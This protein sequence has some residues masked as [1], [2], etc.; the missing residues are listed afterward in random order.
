MVD[1]DEHRIG[2]VFAD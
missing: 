1:K 2:V